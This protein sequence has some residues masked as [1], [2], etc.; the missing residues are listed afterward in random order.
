MAGRVPARGCEAVG[1]ELTDE[2]RSRVVNKKALGK[3][4]CTHVDSTPH[5]H[6]PCD[7]PCLEPSKRQQRLQACVVYLW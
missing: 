3:N 2:Q 7:M 1:S 4:V 6:S 5:S